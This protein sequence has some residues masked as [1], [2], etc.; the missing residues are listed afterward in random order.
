M[1]VCHYVDKTAH[2]MAFSVNGYLLDRFLRCTRVCTF[3]SQ[4]GG[5][6]MLYLALL[7]DLSQESFGGSTGVLRRRT[8]S[9]F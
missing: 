6:D 8:S 3:I 7:Q 5:I 2:A 4:F 1:F 9:C